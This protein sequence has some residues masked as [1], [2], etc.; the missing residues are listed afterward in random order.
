MQEENGWGHPP[1][2]WGE[3]HLVLGIWYLCMPFGLAES[4]D[5]ALPGRMNQFP[6]TKYQLP[7][8]KFPVSIDML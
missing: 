3:R 2:G 8:A 7:D 1:I 4:G 5:V 6:N